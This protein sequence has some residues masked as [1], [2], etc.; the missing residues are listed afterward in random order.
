[1]TRVVIDPGHL[2]IPRQPGHD[3]DFPGLDGVMARRR[4]QRLPAVAVARSGVVGRG[5]YASTCAGGVA[6]LLSCDTESLS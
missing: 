5:L 1:V 6:W 4:L 2:D 3:V